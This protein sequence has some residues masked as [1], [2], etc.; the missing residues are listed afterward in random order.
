MRDDEALL[1]E[2]FG[3]ERALRLPL[4]MHGLAGITD[5]GRSG[6]SRDIY[7]IVART[8]GDSPGE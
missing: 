6:L 7:E 4:V 2:L 8:P 5:R 3:C 1:L